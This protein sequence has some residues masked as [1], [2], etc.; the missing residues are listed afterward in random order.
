MPPGTKAAV[1]CKR[2]SDLITSQ[3]IQHPYCF[4]SYT[5][6]SDTALFFVNQT[7]C[8]GGGKKSVPLF[9]AM[10]NCRRPVFSGLNFT[11]YK[12]SSL[13]S[14]KRSFTLLCI[15]RLQWQSL[16]VS[17]FLQSTVN[18]SLLSSTNIPALYSDITA[19]PL[20]TF[21]LL[22]PVQVQKTSLRLS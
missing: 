19:I 9:T 15:R 7:L 13:F 8:Y 18:F 20:P 22:L 21:L 12:Q 3:W 11:A 6:R 10:A 16:L 4:L 14:K 5:S 2:I 1:C 17:I